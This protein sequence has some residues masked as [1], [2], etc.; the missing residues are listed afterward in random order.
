MPDDKIL[1]A[2]KISANKTCDARESTESN[3][4]P[5]GISIRISIRCRGCA[6]RMHYRRRLHVYSRV[7]VRAISR[8]ARAINGGFPRS[9]NFRGRASKLLARFRAWTDEGRRKEEK[10]RRRGGRERERAIGVPQAFFNNKFR[11]AAEAN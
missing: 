4:A 7:R 2:G 8:I 1:P 6:V 9:T 10:G 11:S 3:F 5:R